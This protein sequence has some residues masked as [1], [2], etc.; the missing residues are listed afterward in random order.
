M[1]GTLLYTFFLSVC[2]YYVLLAFTT[3]I[4]GITE[5]DTQWQTPDVRQYSDQLIVLSKTSN[6]NDH[7]NDIRSLFLAKRHPSSTSYNEKF[8]TCYFDNFD[9]N[10]AK[11]SPFVENRFVTHVWTKQQLMTQIQT[12]QH[13]N[14]TLM[15]DQKELAHVWSQCSYNFN[16]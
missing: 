8:T 11:E 12:M 5:K 10:D 13:Q 2:L 1:F 4:D 3:W 6:G 16:I 15:E 14:W 9:M 7:M